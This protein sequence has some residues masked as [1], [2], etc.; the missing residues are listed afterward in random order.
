MK[1][2]P[3][4]T[5][6]GKIIHLPETLADLKEICKNHG[7]LDDAVLL[8]AG[9]LA[10]SRKTVE[11]DPS[12][13]KP[14]YVHNS[15]DETTDECTDETLEEETNIPLGIERKAFIILIDEDAE[16]KCVL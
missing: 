4:K 15:I 10:M 7:R 5:Q 11:H 13:K 8:L 6:K 2:Y 14:W 9:G 12:K 3:S 16:C 1:I